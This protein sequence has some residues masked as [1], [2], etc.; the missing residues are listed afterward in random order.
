MIL[1]NIMVEKLR[2]FEIIITTT[3]SEDNKEI[4]D[5]KETVQDFGTHNSVIMLFDCKPFDRKIKEIYKCEN[6]DIP[7]EIKKGL[8]NIRKLRAKQK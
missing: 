2:L 7:L 6:I 8:R 5:L 3:F 4:L 1:N